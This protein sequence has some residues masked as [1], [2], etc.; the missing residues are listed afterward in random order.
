LGPSRR[1]RPRIRAT[2]AATRVYFRLS[3]RG[4]V[5]NVQSMH[6]AKNILVQ[7]RKLQS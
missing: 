1:R 3:D 5:G 6:V 2:A 7:L 4:K